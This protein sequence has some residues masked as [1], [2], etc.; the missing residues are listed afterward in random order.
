MKYLVRLGVSVPE[1][2]N[3][4]APSSLL[5][6]P[7]SESSESWSGYV[8]IVDV[9]DGITLKIVSGILGLFSSGLSEGGG[10]MPGRKRRRA[11]FAAAFIYY[12]PSNHH[13][14]YRAVSD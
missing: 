13:T 3:A 7:S 4:L 6:D 5:S 8:G 11:V 14:P 12:Y 2:N 9:K 1:P 10:S